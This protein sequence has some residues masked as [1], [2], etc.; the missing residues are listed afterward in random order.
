MQ[1]S[2]RIAVA[3][4]VAAAL[5]ACIASAPLGETAFAANDKTYGMR[6]YSDPAYGF[7]F[8]YPAALPIKKSKTSDAASFPGGVEVETIEVGPAG[9]VVIHIVNS[10][11]STIT[12]EPNGHA[13]PIGQTKYFYDAS[14]KRWMVAFPEGTSLVGEGATKPADVSKITIGGL[15]M[16][17]GGARFDTTIIP[18]SKTRF[19]VVQDGGGSGFTDQ[20]ARTVALVGARIDA[21]ALTAALQ[22]EAAAYAKQ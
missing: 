8:W 14:A 17:P 12:D 9:D 18:L 16:L 19:F 3:S 5:L 13:A 20:L 21:S 4:I 10:P 2:D 22:A 11:Q 7:S 6:R 15:L 1:S